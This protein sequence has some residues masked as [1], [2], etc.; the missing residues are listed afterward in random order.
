MKKTLLLGLSLFSIGE[1]TTQTF[2]NTNPENRKTILEEFTGINCV[3]CPDGHVIANNIKNANPNNFFVVNIHVGGFSTPNAGQPDFRTPFGNSFASLSGATGYPS[4]TVN[5][6]VF[7]G[8]GQT[9]G[10]TAM[11]RQHWTSTSNQTITLPSYVNTAVQANIN[12]ATNVLT[13]NTETFYTGN[14]PAGTNKINVALLQNN[15]L[16]PQSGGNMGNNYNHQHRLIHMVTGQWGADITP[17]TTGSFHANQFTYQ[18]PA[19]HNGIPI[20]IEDLEVVVFV[21]EGQQRIISGNGGSVTFSGLPT[22]D[23]NIK[24]IATIPQQCSNTLSPKV[25]IQNRSLTNLNTTQIYYNINGGP[26]QTYTWNGN[27]A[28]MQSAEVTLPAVTYNLLAN[29][30]LQVSLNEDDVMENNV[31]TANFA[32]AVETEF[33]NITVRI[34]LDRYASETSWTLKNSAGANVAVS[35]LYNGGFDFPANGTYP[36]PDINLTLPNDCYTFEILDS[37]GD[38]ICCAYGAGGYQ[39][40]ANGVL[41]QGMSGGSFGAGESKRFGVNTTLNVDGFD[42]AAIK[43]YPNPSNGLVNVYLPYEA[44]VTVLDITGKTVYT[45]VLAAGE[46]QCVLNH[47]TTGMYLMSIKGENFS[48]TEKIIIK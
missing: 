22:N 4:G 7:A 21:A 25:T 27:L 44:Q 48:K 17:T 36:Q 39:I 29:N 37:F 43:I 42:T 45:H 12:A 46:N 30:T 19:A 13:V 26:E 41:V 8:L 40:L 14:S 47:L 31:R 6:T 2:V 16:G 15:T 35:P 3:F 38:G 1:A 34:T 18:I 10:G 5:R 32:K 23:V 9:S 24:S 11:G 33:T 28:P 20:L